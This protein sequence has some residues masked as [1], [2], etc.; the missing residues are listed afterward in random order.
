MHTWVLVID[1]VSLLRVG[2]SRIN[3]AGLTWKLLLASSSISGGKLS[4]PP[5]DSPPGTSSP[6]SEGNSAIACTGSPTGHCCAAEVT[7]AM[8]IDAEAISSECPDG[9]CDTASMGCRAV[10][11]QLGLQSCSLATCTHT[12]LWIC[13]SAEAAPSGMTDSFSWSTRRTVATP[14]SVTVTLPLACGLEEAVQPT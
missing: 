10:L 6:A 2:S 4:G 5:A 3:A 14:L 8:A 7:A 12:W 13:F 11:S 1:D 9:T